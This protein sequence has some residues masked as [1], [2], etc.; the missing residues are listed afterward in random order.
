MRALA[1]RA[2]GLRRDSDSFAGAEW[3][4]VCLH[5]TAN[6]WRIDPNGYCAPH[7]RQSICE[8]DSKRR[9]E[10]TGV[11]DNLY[12]IADEGSGSTSKA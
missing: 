8:E 3:F 6:I 10:M 12:R 5:T 7:R 11:L 4:N 9:T 1:L 2:A